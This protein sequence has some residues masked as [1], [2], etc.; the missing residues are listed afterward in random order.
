MNAFVVPSECVVLLL[1][2]LLCCCCWSCCCCCCCCCCCWSCCWSCCC[3]AGLLLLVLLVL[4][5]FFFF[6]CQRSLLQP[7]HARQHP[8]I[9]VQHISKTRFLESP[10]RIWARGKFICNVPIPFRL[11]IQPRHKCYMCQW[12]KR[13]FMLSLPCR[14]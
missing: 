12:N 8:P 11:P 10:H 14:V 13:G 7:R 2:L 5:T 9:V 3:L 4:L 6:F 1:L